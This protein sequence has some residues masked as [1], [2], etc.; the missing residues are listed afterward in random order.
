M[1]VNAMNPKGKEKKEKAEFN[2]RAIGRRD[3]GPGSG[4]QQAAT[5]AHMGLPRLQRSHTNCRQMTHLRTKTDLAAID[6]YLEQMQTTIFETD[7]EVAA[8][9]VDGTWILIAGGWWKGRNG[10]QLCSCFSCT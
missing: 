3:Y 10:K 2:S 8:A 7:T 9:G 4:R 1:Q 5:T 6:T